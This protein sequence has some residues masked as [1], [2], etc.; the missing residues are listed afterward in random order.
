MYV[1]VLGVNLLVLGKVEVLLG[2]ENSLT[3]EVL[4]DELTVGLGNKPI[5]DKNQSQA[6]L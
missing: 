3:E 1:E 2:D 6:P 4:V 5:S